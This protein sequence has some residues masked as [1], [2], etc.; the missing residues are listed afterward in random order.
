M[1]IGVLRLIQSS[2]LIMSNGTMRKVTD[3]SKLYSLDWKHKVELRDGIKKI[4]ERY[5]GL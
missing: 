5:K 4:Y 1:F 2:T 3:I